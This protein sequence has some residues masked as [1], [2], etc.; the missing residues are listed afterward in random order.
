[1]NHLIAL[2]SLVALAALVALIAL[3]AL[4]AVLELQWNQCGTNQGVHIFQ[5]RQKEAR[6][7]RFF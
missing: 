5:G 4:V 3:A 7:Q 6:I 1:M 2:A